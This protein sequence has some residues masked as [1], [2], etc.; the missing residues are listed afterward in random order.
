MPGIGLV[1]AKMLEAAKE[2]RSGDKKRVKTG[3]K[4]PINRRPGWV[5]GGSV[6]FRRL[7]GCWRMVWPAVVDGW[8]LMLQ[9]GGFWPFWEPE[10][11]GGRAAAGG[12]GGAV[13]GCQVSGVMVCRGWLGGGDPAAI[14]G[15]NSAVFNQPLTTF[16][17]I[18]MVWRLTVFFL[19][20]Y[21]L[22]WRWLVRFRS[23]GAVV[24]VGGLVVVLDELSTG[25]IKGG[26]AEKG[27]GS[28]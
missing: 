21:C 7:L 12:G 1:L 5:P 16:L 11:Q 4:T 24:E 27:R 28:S 23:P 6:V 25:T 3:V 26:V 10:R 9:A 8:R 13:G 20:S 22:F 14:C 18:A 17:V 15:G 2:I 19:C